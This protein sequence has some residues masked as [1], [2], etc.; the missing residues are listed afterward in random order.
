[1][2]QLGNMGTSFRSTGCL[3]LKSFFLPLS[4]SLTDIKDEQLYVTDPRALHHIIVKE[5]S[6]FEEPQSLLV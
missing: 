2:K 4:P 1:M 5:Q 3:G 6:I